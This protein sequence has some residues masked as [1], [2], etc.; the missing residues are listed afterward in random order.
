VVWFNVVKRDV[1]GLFCVGVWF[2]FVGVDLERVR[3]RVEEIL[4]C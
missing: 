1:W 3:V 2:Q 4:D